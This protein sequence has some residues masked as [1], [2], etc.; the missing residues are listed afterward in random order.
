MAEYFPIPEWYREQQS[1]DRE[2]TYADAIYENPPNAEQ[3]TIELPDGPGLSA[4][5]N[6]E[7]LE[8]FAVE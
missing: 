1:E 6:R 5:L 2:S 3:G 4:T 8:H 7:A